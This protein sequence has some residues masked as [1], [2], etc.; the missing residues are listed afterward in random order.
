MASVDKQLLGT[1]ASFRLRTKGFEGL[2]CGLSAN[3][4]A[5]AFRK[6]GADAFLQ[7]PFSCDRQALQQDILDVLNSRHAAR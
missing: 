3:D 4:M 6:S 2:I 5:E 1:E 7:K